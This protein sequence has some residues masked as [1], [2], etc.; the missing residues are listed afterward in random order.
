GRVRTEPAQ[1]G[2]ERAPLAQ[3]HPRGSL[4]RTVVPAAPDAGQ[5]A[6]PYRAVVKRGGAGF[7]F[8]PAR[9]GERQSL[10]PPAQ[11]PTGNPPHRPVPF[12]PFRAVHP[13]VAYGEICRVGGVFGT[14]RFAK[15]W[16]PKTPPTLPPTTVCNPTGNRSNW[17]APHAMPA[18]SARR[19][20]RSAPAAR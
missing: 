9:G 18:P 1:A 5:T 4:A 12:R 6:E 8:A 14:H 16:V 15:W 17:P 7:R 19:H 10:R 20:G 3:C 13:G 11:P 2:R